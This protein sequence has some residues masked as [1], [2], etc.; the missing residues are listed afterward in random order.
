M[1]RNKII[2]FREL[3]PGD[4]NE[5]SQFLKKDSKGYNKYFVPFSFEA[6]AIENILTNKHDDIYYGVYWGEVLTGFYMLR[7]FDEGYTIPSYGVY[8]SSRFSNKGLATLT[9]LHAIST[10]KL[11]GIKKLM[12]KVHKEHTTAFDLYKK[13]GFVE[14][15]FD[16]RISNIIMH[17]ELV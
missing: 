16:E 7:G 5:L 2:N 8:I 10:C 13:F 4:A 1:S 15:G 9:L 3:V 17:K 11:R 12:L 14:T 6:G